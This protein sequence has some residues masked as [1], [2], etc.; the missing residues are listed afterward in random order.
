MPTVAIK[1]AASYSVSAPVRLIIN[2]TLSDKEGNET[3]ERFNR[4]VQQFLNISISLLGIVPNDQAV[5][6]A[7]NRQM[8]FLLQN[9]ASK[10]SISLIEMVNMLIPQD[11]RTT[12]KT[13]GMFIRRLKRFFL[14]R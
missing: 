6:K 1:L 2:K 5:Q 14:E 12:A 10:A 11:N 8:P 7:V 4:A 13:E 9:P 3:Y